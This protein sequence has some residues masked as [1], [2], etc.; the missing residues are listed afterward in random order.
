MYLLSLYDRSEINQMYEDLRASLQKITNI[1]EKNKKK[2]DDLIQVFIN[3]FKDYED[4]IEYRL[5]K[6]NET[7]FIWQ[8][9]PSELNLWNGK[10]FKNNKEISKCISSELYI[11][12]I[13]G[14]E[15]FYKEKLSL[16]FDKNESISNLGNRDKVYYKAVRYNQDEDYAR[17]IDKQ[18]EIKNSRWRSSSRN[19]TGDETKEA[20]K[21]LK[22][23]TK[24][25]KLKNKIFSANL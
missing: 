22:Y 25:L 16:N 23:K 11:D 12:M 21:Y 6:D 7:L 1:T 10:K 8:I 15:D 5:H 19:K 4:I 14:A 2:I 18:K 9:D 20:K 17:Y 24:Y 13:T 3:E